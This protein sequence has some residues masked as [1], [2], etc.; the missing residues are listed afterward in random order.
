LLT[1][2]VCLSIDLCITTLPVQLQQRQQAAGHAV[3]FTRCLCLSC[4]KQVRNPD[5][6]G[7]DAHI[8]ARTN[9]NTNGSLVLGQV[10]D[11]FGEPS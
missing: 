1:H 2:Q 4:S 7:V 10:Q 5:R 3:L 9:R 8:A 6:G 11:C